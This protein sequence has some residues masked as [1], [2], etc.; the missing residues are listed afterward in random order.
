MDDAHTY[1]MPNQVKK[2]MVA[3]IGVIDKF[4]AMF[5]LKPTYILAT[6]PE[7]ALGLKSDWDKAEKSLSDALKDAGKEFKIAEGEGAFYGPK[8]EAHLIDSQGRDWQMAT[9]QL[10][11]V[12]LPKQFETYYVA[13]DGSKKLPW[14]IHRAFFGSFERFIGMLLEHTDGRLPL[15]LSPVQ[16][17]IMSIAESHAKYAKQIAKKLSTK[18]IRTKLNIGNDTIGKKIREAELRHVPY[19]LIVGEKEI[20]AKTVSARYYKTKESQTLPVKDL[21]KKLLAEIKNKTF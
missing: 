5:D 11:L 10:D 18:G 14:V 8:I 3:I 6:R 16:A 15:W 12:M 7:K 1:A 20:A 13:K 9:E 2:E 4:Y 19:I 17:E 21:V